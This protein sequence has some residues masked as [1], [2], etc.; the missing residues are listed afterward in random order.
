MDR[1]GWSSQRLQ[2]RAFHRN[3]EAIVAWKKAVL[4][5]IKKTRDLNASL[6]LEDEAGFT[7][8]S[9]PKRT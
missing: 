2:R 7:M 4:P 9:P 3:E 6:G 1:M 8:V 5:E